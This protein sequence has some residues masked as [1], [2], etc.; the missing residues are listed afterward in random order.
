MK[1]GIKISL[2]IATILVI[3][4]LGMTITVLAVNN[5][6]YETLNFGGKIETKEAL[7]N[8]DFNNININV[9]TMEISFIKTSDA[10]GKIIY[11]QRVNT[12]F[13]ISV[14]AG[15][16]NVRQTNIR[17]FFFFT[18]FF[19][20]KTKMDIYLPKDTYNNLILNTAT[21]HINIPKEFTFDKINIDSETGNINLFA[22]ANEIS[23]E[24]ETGR[25]HLK[26]INANN[27]VIETSTGSHTL[28]NVNVT[29]L[30]K[31]KIETGRVTLNNVKMDNLR[32][33]SST[34]RVY[35]TNV[36]AS[37]RFDINAGTGSIFLTS[38]DAAEIYIKTSTGNVTGTLLTSKIFYC[39]A[40]TGRINVPK[41]TTGGICDIE[42]ETGNIDI[43]IVNP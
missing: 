36:I 21:G 32:V 14:A 6:D 37:G 11:D 1:K 22:K 5:F 19:F 25:V 38:S 16:L 43:T 4:G 18:G 42:T 30:I 33:N 15:T 13:E 12:N 8:E 7:L 34:G 26:D 39:K 24:T 17:K 28:E 20:K 29:N 23:I 41:T 27:I 31:L 35:L 10:T 2:I 3:L 9:D 40:E